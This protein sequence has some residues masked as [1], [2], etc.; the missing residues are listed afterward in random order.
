MGAAAVLWFG[1]PFLKKTV[2]KFAIVFTA[3]TALL[4]PLF[5]FAPVLL[6]LWLLLSLAFFTLYYFNK[7]AY[8]YYITDRSV[9][10]VKSWVF[11]NYARELTFDQIRDVHVSQGILARA[12]NCGSVSFVTAAGLEVRHVATGV[13][14][15]K[16]VLIGGGG[17]RPALLKGRGNNFWDVRDP[18]TVKS[19]LV[20]RLAEW[21]EVFQQQ[22]IAVSVERIAERTSPPAQQPAAETLVEQ[23]ERLRKLLDSGAITREEYEKAK[24]KLLET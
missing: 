21:R 24:R 10:I 18:L 17:A 11:G 13:A 15:G 12:F 20:G 3:V 8:T 23:L 14:V 2:V 16:G 1:K 19:V 6:A 7:R 22:R 9:R 5:V 4:T